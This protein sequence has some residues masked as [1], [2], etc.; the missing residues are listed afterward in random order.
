MSKFQKLINKILSGNSDN[1]IDFDDLVKLLLKLNFI[2]RNSG[3]SHYIFYK[4]DISEIINLQPK[5]GKAKPYQVKQVR[6]LITKYKLLKD[7]N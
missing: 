7:E 4:E 1:N 6:E 3:G 5:D 2:Q